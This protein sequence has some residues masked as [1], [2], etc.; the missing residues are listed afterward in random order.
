MV[1]EEKNLK[2]GSPAV[3]VQQEESFPHSLPYHDIAKKTKR[4]S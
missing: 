3:N 2:K 1:K 4:S